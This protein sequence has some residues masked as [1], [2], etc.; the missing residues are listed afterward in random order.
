MTGIGPRCLAEG[1]GSALL[2]TAVVGSGISAA[3]LGGD[4]ALVLLANAVATGAALVALITV[5]A[6]LSGAHLNPVVTLVTHRRGGIPGRDALAYLGAQM[7]GGLA[8]VVAANLMFGLAP[9]AAATKVRTGAGVWFGEVLATAGLLLFAVGGRPRRPEVAGIVVGAYI[10]GAYFFTSSTSFANP[11]VTVA[12]SLT[13]TYTGIAPRSVPAFLGAQLVG[14]AVF[15]LLA[16]LLGG[17][18]RAVENPARR[19]DEEAA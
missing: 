17:G 1:L 7:V 12:R 15:V 13:D 6:P 9:L 5:L 8:G 10:T 16:P 2:V 18:A 11:A 3:R 4:P 19:V 14:A